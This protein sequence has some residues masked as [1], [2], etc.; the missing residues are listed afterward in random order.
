M[1]KVIVTSHFIS[2]VFVESAFYA[3]K[4]HFFQKKNLFFIS[5][6]VNKNKHNFKI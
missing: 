6:L 1:D 5:Q 4:K 2:S 3:V